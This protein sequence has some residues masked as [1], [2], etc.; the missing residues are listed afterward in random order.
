MFTKLPFGALLALSLSGCMSNAIPGALCGARPAIES[1]TYS[2]TASVDAPGYSQQE[3]K[4]FSCT[5]V[6]YACTETGWIP[7][8]A[9][10]GKQDAIFAFPFAQGK[11]LRVNLPLCSAALSA[12][13]VFSGG[14]FTGEAII[15]T[16]GQTF[17]VSE[18][19]LKKSEALSVFGVH[20]S[21]Y[22][23]QQIPTST[24]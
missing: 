8:F 18:Q 1:R 21:S 23:V 15:E 5:P 2:A 17:W 16:A 10:G 20:L 6:S 3:S 11:T 13:I 9:N 4:E 19:D 22:S 24:P 12:P 14:K 7:H